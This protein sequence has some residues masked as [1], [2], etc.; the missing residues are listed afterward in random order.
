MIAAPAMFLTL[1]FNIM[2][3]ARSSLCSGK[4]YLGDCVETAGP[5]GPAQ[6]GLRQPTVSHSMRWILPESRRK[7]ASCGPSRRNILARGMPR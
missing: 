3:L 6:E 2:R 1:E 7:T 5:A 4:E